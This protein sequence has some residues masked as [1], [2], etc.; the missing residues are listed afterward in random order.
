M[1]K[2]KELSETSRNAI[3]VLSEAGKKQME[4]SKQLNI[5]QSTISYTLT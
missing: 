5:P 2:I 1:V 3:K 4:I